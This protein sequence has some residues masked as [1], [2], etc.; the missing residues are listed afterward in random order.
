[1]H[2]IGTNLDFKRLSGRSD[3]RYV[4]GLIHIALRI[5]DIVL[6]TSGI[7]RIDA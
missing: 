4:N 3:N 2:F 1:M 7:E 5:V 6:E